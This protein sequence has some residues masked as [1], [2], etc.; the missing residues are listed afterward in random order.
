LLR[1]P[2]HGASFDASFIWKRVSANLIAYARGRVFDVEPNFGAS[3][4]L[5]YN[6]GYEWLGINLNLRVARGLTLYGNLRNAL[7]ERYEEIFGY[8][9]P[10][11]NFVS[12]VKWTFTRE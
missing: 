8:P 12:G 7:N 2:R 10:R 4:G 5:F 6:P 3:S 11:L 9:S 1:R